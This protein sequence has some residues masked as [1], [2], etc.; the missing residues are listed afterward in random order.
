MAKSEGMTPLQWM[1][2]IFLALRIIRHRMFIICLGVLLV[3]SLRSGV[4]CEAYAVQ[5]Q[6]LTADDV[7]AMIRH[8]ML[9]QGPWQMEQI[10]VTVRSFA[11]VSLPT[12]SVTVRVLQ[13]RKGIAAGVQSF[14][15]GFVVGGR[16]VKTVWAQAEVQIFDEVMVTSKPLAYLE[17][18][19]P[20][21]VR[22]ARREV[23][24][25]FTRP[26]TKIEDVAARQAARAIPVNQ[27][28][29]P[30]MVQLPQV[31]RSGS[32]VTLVYENARVRAEAAGQAVE[33]GKVGD[34]IR[35]KNIS[36][37]QILEGQ[38]V[39]SHEVIIRR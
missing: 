6:I 29:T 9:Q 22:R 7:A 21:N 1:N 5:G 8:V 16:Q 18:I 13:P 37:G 31:V 11:P 10:E 36:S 27:I 23:S 17:A 28:L 3:S 24:T 33:G 4:P 32:P 15:L 14:Q 19:T 30:T 2:S 26:F 35:V 39:N 12:G 34:V 20:E 38:V 25:L